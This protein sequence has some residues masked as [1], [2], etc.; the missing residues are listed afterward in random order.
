LE[1]KKTDSFFPLLLPKT[2]A[3]LV[4]AA[5]D[6]LKISNVNCQVAA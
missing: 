5:P 6:G 1:K 2:H 4:D 3:G